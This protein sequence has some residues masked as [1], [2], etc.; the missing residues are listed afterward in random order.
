MCLSYSLHV[1]VVAVVVR[2]GNNGVRGRGCLSEY[3][4]KSVIFSPLETFSK[5]R[6]VHAAKWHCFP[7]FSANSYLTTRLASI[8]RNTQ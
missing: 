7:S 3:E 1:C 6:E 8:W 2:Q 5:Q 4:Q